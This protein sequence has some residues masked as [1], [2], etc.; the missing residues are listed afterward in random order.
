MNIKISD[1]GTPEDT[2]SCTTTTSPIREIE[3]TKKGV[4]SRAEGAGGIEAQK[5]SRFKLSENSIKERDYRRII[6]ASMLMPRKS[7]SSLGACDIE[8]RRAVRFKTIT[9]EH[10]MRSNGT[11]YIRRTQH[12]TP[13]QNK[14]ASKLNP[15]PK[16]G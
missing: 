16:E 15:T 13:C 6:N 11:G 9:R 3:M 4:P 14:D 5:L 2:G 7:D 12:A 10:K 8:E 1:R